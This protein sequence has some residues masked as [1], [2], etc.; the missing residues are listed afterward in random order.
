MKSETIRFIAVNAIIAAAYAALTVAVAPLSYGNIQFRFSEILLFL[1][2]F[3]KRFFPGL[4]LGCFIANL[5]SPM[6][7]YDITFGT[8]A[9][10]IACAGSYFLGKLV[11]KATGKEEIGLFVVPVVGAVANGFLVGLALHLALE[12]PYWITVLEV[13]LGEG[14]VLLAGAFIFLGISKIP[15]IRRFLSWQY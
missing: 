3:D 7:A 1:A 10:A 13:A 2:F 12:L 4:I 8:A 15:V 5:F 9:T 11:T 6:I 14:A